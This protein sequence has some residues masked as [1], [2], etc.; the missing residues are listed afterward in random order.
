VSVRPHLR[1]PDT[2]SLVE[3][4]VEPQLALDGTAL[5]LQ[6]IDEAHMHRREVPALAL[7]IHAQ[8]DRR[9]GSQP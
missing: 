7:G 9:A 8:R 5:A 4:A 1:E 2:L 6:A 3:L